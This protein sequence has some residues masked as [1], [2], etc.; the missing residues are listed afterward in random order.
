M[1]QYINKA[2]VVT[3]IERMLEVITNDSEQDVRDRDLGAIYSAQLLVLRNFAKYLDTLEVKEMETWHLQEKEDI[4]DAVKDWGLYKFVCIMK[5]GTIQ[6]FNGCLDEDCEGHI[7]VHINGI[8]DDY[9]DVDDI[10]KWIE[11]T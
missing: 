5:D 8:N 9:D 6:R 2:A 4:Y 10:V 7:N 11:I 1:T 3:E